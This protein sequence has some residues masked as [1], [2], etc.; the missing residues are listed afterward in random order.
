[1]A[2]YLRKLWEILGNDD[3]VIKFI[4]KCKETNLLLIQ[5][6]FNSKFAANAF[7]LDNYLLIRE[8][9]KKTKQKYTRNFELKK[10]QSNKD[11]TKVNISIQIFHRELSVL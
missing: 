5:K 6:Q 7:A 4:P 2:F 8:I 11:N 9:T 10:N 1:M 3:F